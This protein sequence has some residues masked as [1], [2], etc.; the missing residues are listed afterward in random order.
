MTDVLLESLRIRRVRPI[1]LKMG[2]SP[3]PVRDV[4]APGEASFLWCQPWGR[5]WS[6]C[7]R[8]RKGWWDD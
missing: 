2:G 8:G 1:V 3:Q 7:R 4:L 6:R 5:S